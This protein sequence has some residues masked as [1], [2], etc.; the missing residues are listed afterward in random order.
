[1]R[2]QAL[3]FGRRAGRFARRAFGY[4]GVQIEGPV[5]DTIA[6]ELRPHSAASGRDVRLFADAINYGASSFLRS[7]RRSPDGRLNSRVTL[8]LGNALSLTVAVELCPAISGFGLV[9]AQGTSRGFSWNWFSRQ[10]P[11]FF[12]WGSRCVQ[13]ELEERPELELI[14]SIYF[15]EDTS[16]SFSPELPLTPGEPEMDLIVKRGSRLRFLIPPAV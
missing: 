7:E 10:E 8:A 12:R 9:V 6:Y 16:L 3:L 2:H 11:G 1:M 15:V 5:I 4:V 13:V 14:S